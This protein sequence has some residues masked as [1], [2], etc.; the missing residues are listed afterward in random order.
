MACAAWSRFEVG[1]ALS[2]SAFTRKAHQGLA[3]ILSGI[4]SPFF[5][6]LDL[7]IAPSQGT[8]LRHL[9][10][11]S[12]AARPHSP[13]LTSAVPPVCTLLCTSPPDRCNRGTAL[14][15]PAAHQRTHSSSW[16]QLRLP[17]DSNNPVNDQYSS[18]APRVTP[19]SPPQPSECVT[20]TPPNVYP[21]F[22]AKELRS[23][24]Q[25]SSHCHCQGLGQVFA[26]VWNPAQRNSE[27]T[28]RD[29]VCLKPL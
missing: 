8:K 10:G 29:G 24:P 18:T 28:S 5:H 14:R 22:Q 25:H 3:R 20:L 6:T 21:A 26:L 16:T 27:S 1:L 15:P 13:V 4:Q 19:R 11:Q 2:T 17:Q 9:L 12:R 23:P 7:I